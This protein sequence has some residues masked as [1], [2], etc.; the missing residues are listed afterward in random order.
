MSSVMRKPVFRMCE[1]KG[2]DQ[3]RDNL[4]AV[5]RLCFRYIDSAFTL[6]PT[7]EISVHSLYFLHMKLPVSSH[8]LLWYS[9]VCVGSCQEP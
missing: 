2:A 8:I 4:A 3:L 5:Q 9:P 6:L 1:N 7:Y